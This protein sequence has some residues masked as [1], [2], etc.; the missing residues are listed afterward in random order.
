M[1][2]CDNLINKELFLVK[3]EKLSLKVERLIE[4]IALMKNKLEKSYKIN[5]SF[6]LDAIR[7]SQPLTFSREVNGIGSP[8]KKY[9]FSIRSVSESWKG[10]KNDY[11]LAI[12][13][14]DKETRKDLK[15]LGIRIPIDDIKNIETLAREV[16]SLLYVSCEL[17]G[18]EI[19]EILRDILTQIN[20]NGYE[21]VQEVKR[22]MM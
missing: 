11:L 15:A 14:Q 1:S 8:S 3:F 7:K 10:R 20:D 2:E 12:R 9:I 18:I 4:E 22:K 17:K 13:Q 6:G 21:M 19:N 5:R 16:I